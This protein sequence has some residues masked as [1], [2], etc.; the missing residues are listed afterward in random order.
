MSGVRPAD[1]AIDVRRRRQ[2]R[3]M[4]F[5]ALGSASALSTYASTLLSKST[6]A[7]T[8]GGASATAGKAD[9]AMKSAANAAL[10]TA[11]HTLRSTVAQSALEQKEN[12]L[13]ADLRS[14]MSKAG[15]K[16]GGTVEFSIGSDGA[17]AVSGSDA[18]K[19]AVQGFLKNDK[20]SPGFVARVKTLASD[21][22]ALSTQLRQSAAISQAARYAGRGGNVMQLY[23]TL[24]AQQDASKAVFSLSDSASS[25]TYP[26]AMAWKA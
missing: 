9:A 25:L 19:A 20:S 24:L 2:H 12:A 21:T 5:N 6:T 11:S 14:A 16:L 17:L 7:T 22:D 13:A 15:V 23:G 1:A 4:N 26:G 3:A 8:S 10:S 18:D